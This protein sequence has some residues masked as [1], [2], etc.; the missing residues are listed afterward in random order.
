MNSNSDKV[1]ETGM[2]KGRRR[3]C[4][5]QKTSHKISNL[6]WLQVFVYALCCYVNKMSLSWQSGKCNFDAGL[7]SLFGIFGDCVLLVQC[8]DV[9]QALLNLAE[10]LGGDRPRG[11]T[12]T[13]CEAAGIIPL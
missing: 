12:K 2:A 8:Y 13:E 6:C 9:F 1:N 7:T 3:T 11:M 4:R 5:S 10:L